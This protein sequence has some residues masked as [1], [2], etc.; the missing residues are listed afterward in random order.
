ME[1]AQLFLLQCG[2]TGSGED[3][4]KSLARY[5]AQSLGMDYVCID[6]L[7]GEG[8]SARTV[9]VYFD[10][11]FED[12]VTYTLKDTPCGEVVGKTICCFDREVQQLFPEDVVLQEMR[13]E[14]YV[15]TTLWSFDGKPI[16]LIAVISRRP[17]ANPRLAESMLKMAALRAAGELERLQVLDVLIDKEKKLRIIHDALED[18][19]NERTRAL[20]LTNEHLLQEIEN[21]LQAEQ[22][23]KENSEFIQK[24]F[25][26]SPMGIIAYEASGQCVMVNNAASRIIGAGREVILQ[27]NFNHLDSWKASGLLSAAREVLQTNQ[28]R[29]NLK[30]HLV[31]T[32][33]KDVLLNG[34]LIPFSS[35]NKP[36][37]LLMGQDVSRQN[38]AEEA[39]RQS[40]R[41]ASIGLL[42]AG[43]AHEISNPNGFIIFNLP[44]LR[45]YLQ[46]LMPIVDDYMAD[47]PDR[48]MFGR[49]YEDFRKDLFKLLDNVEHGAHRI[50]ATVSGL[51]DLSRK[52]EKLKP[53]RVALKPVIENAVSICREEIRKNV[54]SLHLDVPENLLPIL[55]DPDALEQVLV[56]LLIN[57]AHASDK[58]DSWIKLGVSADSGKP[59]C[60]IIAIDD[61]GCGMDEA[62]LKRIFD[63]FYTRKQSIRGTG[64]GLYICQSLVEGLG[65]RIEVESRPDL[66]SSF[67]VILHDLL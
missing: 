35:A 46:E 16:G 64:L 60:C 52:R 7:E 28:P 22:D 27:Q 50:N 31:T 61:N 40:Q 62:T 37:L 18:L 4:F 51:K 9:A 55:T 49:H 15:G 12:N 38:Q 42:V 45:D 11:K 65:G 32:F 13:A 36:H 53:R 47:H 30:L 56:N 21:R 41:L 29:E 20:S 2:S 1:D 66:G 17:L 63:P 5:L 26:T 67:K 59:D 23:L 39:L 33:G 54:K 57:A 19:V 58:E 3:F 10:G 14:S 43:V 6:R 34:S 44:I 24:I 48:S 8:L 25:D